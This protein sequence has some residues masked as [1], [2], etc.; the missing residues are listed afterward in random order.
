MRI[1]KYT[2]LLWIAALF[3]ACDRSDDADLEVIM[4]DGPSFDESTEWGIRM[5]EFYDKWGIWCQYNV[6]SDDLFYAWTTSENWTTSALDYEY[7]DADPEY[8]VKA[9]DFLEE[10]VMANL[11][12][13]ILNEYMGLYIALEGRVFHSNTLEDGLN[14][15]SM[16]DWNLSTD[17]DEE[18][19]GWNGTRHLLLAPVS[20]LF[21]EMDKDEI[22][23]GWTAL[24]FNAALANL[25]NPDAFEEN[26]PEPFFSLGYFYYDYIYD[27]NGTHESGWE[28]PSIFGAYDPYSAGYVKA[29]PL[30]SVG[31]SDGY[32]DE[33]NKTGYYVCIDEWYEAPTILDAF[34]DYVAYI[35]YASPEEK[36]EIRSMNTKIEE[37]E[38][39][40]KD[41]CKQYLNWDIPELGK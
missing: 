3:V 26:N 30:L 18:A 15:S 39:L 27:E 20:S 13:S 28:E 16:E 10:E 21:D 41:Y 40:V 35:M 4:P 1:C 25:P 22:K 7:E 14:Y 23:R 33:D 38:Q 37:N 19:Y 32:D 5:K 17:Y 8:I 9:L 31:L 29:G 11:P 24:L 6:P 12:E 34:A 2:L 36:A